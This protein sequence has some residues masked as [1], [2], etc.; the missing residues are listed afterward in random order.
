V[1]CLTCAGKRLG[2]ADTNWESL[3]G[4]LTAERLMLEDDGRRIA[5]QIVALQAQ[6]DK[7]KTGGKALPAP[8]VDPHFL[9]DGMK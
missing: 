5:D 6:I 1:L 4:R 2:E 9:V 8:A 7:L 3:I